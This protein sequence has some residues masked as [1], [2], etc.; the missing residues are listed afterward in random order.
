MKILIIRFSSIG[1]IVLTT[2]V[3]RCLK[4]Q[5]KDSE[6]HYLTKEK[7]KQVLCENPYIDKL[8][9]YNSNYKELLPILRKEKFDYI[10]DL[11]SNQR[12][13]L[14]KTALGVK[15]KSVN[16]INLEKWLMVKFKKN[17]LPQ[18]HM[19]DRYMETT[20]DLKIINDNEG[21]DYF[22]N[23]ED[24]LDIA[25]TFP[26]IDTEKYIAFVIGGSYFTRRLPKEKVVSICK[27][28][29]LPVV[30][31]GGPEE[32]ETGTEII[33]ELKNLGYPHCVNTCGKLKL[34]QSASIVKQASFVI[35]N[36]TGL[37]H[38]ATAYGK[39][40]AALWGNTI[41]EFGM[42]PYR[43]NKEQRIQNFEVKGLPCRP[44]SKI[45]VDH[46][47]KGHFKCMADI[48]EEEIL[49]FVTA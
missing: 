19:V 42:L 2:P 14:I 26:N 36:D 28:L 38:I 18:K 17:R 13:L 10:I 7:F 3:V 5:I 41:P 1:D 32:A 40:I 49:G 11:H 30:L 6:V 25:Q 47:P 45:G 46:C 16:K 21:L 8:H 9:L 39:D 24:E 37:M 34:N 23:Q 15:N 20:S 31:C 22:I 35:T 12:S 44:C 4:K 29:D 27:Q 33:Q 48:N 43:K